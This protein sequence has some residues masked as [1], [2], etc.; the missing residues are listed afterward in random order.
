MIKFENL[1]NTA[2]NQLNDKDINVEVSV[3]R[4]EE[5]KRNYLVAT[6]KMVLFGNVREARYQEEIYRGDEVGTLSLFVGHFDEYRI[7]QMA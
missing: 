5:R 6:Y 4:D 7:S 2:Q 1:R 3:E